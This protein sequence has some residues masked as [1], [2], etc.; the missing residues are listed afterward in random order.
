MPDDWLSRHIARRLAEIRLERGLTIRQLSEM[1]GIP[2]SSYHRIESGA[3][4]VR[5]ETLYLI[6]SAL[7]SRIGDVWPD[8]RP[9]IRHRRDLW[10]P[11]ND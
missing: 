9:E 3:P 11:D 5:P 2:A 7:Q 4:L 8:R 10:S 6:L 1:T